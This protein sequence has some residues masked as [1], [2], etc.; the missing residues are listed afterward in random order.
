MVFQDFAHVFR[1]H[2][3]L[4]RFRVPK[5]P[6]VRVPFR[7]QILPFASCFVKYK[8]VKRLVMLFHSTRTCT[9]ANRRRRKWENERTDTHK[10]TQTKTEGRKKTQIHVHLPPSID[11]F[12]TMQSRSRHARLERKRDGT[13]TET[14]ERRVSLL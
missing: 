9:A 8:S 10:H 11:A 14:V 12:T 6:L 4:L 1:R 13:S 3:F 2:L 7:V 5:L